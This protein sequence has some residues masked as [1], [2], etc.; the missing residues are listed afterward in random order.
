MRIT[1]KSLAQELDLAQSTVSMA[2]RDHP[3][4]SPSTRQR[5]HDA[6]QRLNYTP[7]H[8]ARSMVTGRT[9]VIGFPTESIKAE[10]IARLF[11]GAMK[12]AFEA[13]YLIKAIPL[14]TKMTGKQI[15]QCCIEHCVCA[16]VSVPM[17]HDRLNDMSHALLSHGIPMGVMA[18][19]F[20]DSL[21]L[22]VITDDQ[23]G[24]KQAIEHLLDMGHRTIGYLDGDPT[25]ASSKV[26]REGY[27][28][29]LKDAGITPA[30]QHQ[31]ETNFDSVQ[32]HRAVRTML[33]SKNNRP[34]AIVC[35][36]DQ[37]AMVTMRTARQ[38]GFC[39]PND[40]SVIGFSNL[41]MAEYADP[42]LTSVNQSWSEMG[43]ITT[44]QII[45]AIET[46]QTI[47]EQWGQQ[48]VMPAKL[49][50]RE[51]TAPPAF[52]PSPTPAMKPI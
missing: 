7:N 14:S 24:M 10:H 11:D 5:V 47:D 4:I 34:T 49:I 51:S 30:P 43:Y 39:V 37:T 9:C 20:S 38:L 23:G 52:E 32:T 46:K 44:Q 31:V 8:I 2:L 50:V 48:V 19:S 25:T 18:N 6:A 12:A 33:S 3:R 36:N 35:I 22:R 17:Q 45:L 26:R 41:S 42:P 40:L 29:T 27:L 13:G 21:G 1:C 28:K 16:V 15:A